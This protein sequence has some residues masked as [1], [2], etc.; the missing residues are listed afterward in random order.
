MLLCVAERFIRSANCGPHAEYAYCQS[1]SPDSSSRW[2][3]R[4]FVPQ[5]SA[6]KVAA[7]TD[8]TLV[9]VESPSAI[10]ETVESRNNQLRA[11]AAGLWYH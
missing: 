4:T 6:I 1:V 5:A 11:G 10:S 9:R 2:G 3:I 8:T 7:T